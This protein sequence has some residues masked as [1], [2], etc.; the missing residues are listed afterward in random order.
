MR[1]FIITSEKFNGTAELVYG[2]NEQLIAIDMRQAS[3][4]ADVKIAF[5][6]AAPVYL[7]DMSTAFTAGT[8]VVE[9]DFVISFKQFYDE[10]PLKRNRYKAEQVFDRMNTIEQ[11]KAYYSLKD[12]NRYCS[13]NQWY[14]AM[15]A[16]K[17]LR[18]KEYETD[19]NK[20]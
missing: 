5:K 15:I 17:Y 13:R 3:M 12:F 16:D 10:Y 4:A 9:A 20:L 18:N 19:W 8:T 14:T 1:R 2:I 7:A 6:R 11:V